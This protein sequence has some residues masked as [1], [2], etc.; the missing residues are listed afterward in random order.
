MKKIFSIVILATLVGFQ[1]YAENQESPKFSHKIHVGQ[2]VGCEDCHDDVMS[3]DKSADYLI[4]DMEVCYGCHEKDDV[5]DLSQLPKIA[6]YRVDFPHKTHAEEGDCLT[7]H[8]GIQEK[9]YAGMP[10]HLPEKESCG[11][12]HSPTDYSE[13]K[14]SCLACHKDNFSFKPADHGLNWKQTHGLGISFSTD[15]CS[16]C[17]Q[18]YYCESC[19][20]GDNI[21]HDAHPFNYKHTHGIR[22]KVNKENC[23]TCHQEYAFCIQ[24]HQMEMVKP[25]NHLNPS[26]TAGNQHGRSA[27][28]DFDACQVCHSSAYSDVTCLMCHN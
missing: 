18:S 6:D 3:S 28:Y 1:V 12:C 19:H 5:D 22:A 8:D 27:Q 26:W 9:E 24:C 13:E 2:E 17:H 25:M 7:C 23:L 11:T 14:K 4:P 20:E 21:D 15:A 10:Y 16:H